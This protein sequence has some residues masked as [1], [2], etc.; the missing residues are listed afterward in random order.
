MKERTDAD[1]SHLAQL[2]QL[3]D[4]V[5][6]GEHNNQSLQYSPRS[7]QLYLPYHNSA[8]AVCSVATRSMNNDISTRPATLVTCR[9]LAYANT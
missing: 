7:L 8:A 6:A 1:R 2:L 9:S 4:A 5:S 3:N